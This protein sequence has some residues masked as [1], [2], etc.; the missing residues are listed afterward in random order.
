[1]AAS[2]RRVQGFSLI[3]AL[4][5]SAVLALIV[6][7]MTQ[8]VASG[9]ALT[10]N[11]LHEARALALAEALMEEVLS[12]PYVDPDGDTAEGPDSGESVRSTF[13]AI[14]DYDG[15]TEA[16]GALLDP[17]GVAYPERHQ[18]FSRRVAAEY[19]SVSLT[20]L[21]GS[22]QVLDVTVVVADGGGREWMIR[23]SVAEPGS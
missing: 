11:A 7:G 17:A 10:Y 12:R 14:D 9:Q 15:Y 23:R 19:G 18:A 21:G 22:R 3:E 20:A 4:F 2:G 13:D 6:A 8:S 16:A 1:V 5:A